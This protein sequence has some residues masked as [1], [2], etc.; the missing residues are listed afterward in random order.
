MK[1][2]YSDS[3]VIP[4][5]T[6]TSP[7][8]TYVF[9]KNQSNPVLSAESSDL[10]ES[11]IAVADVSQILVGECSGSSANIYGAISGSARPYE[12]VHDTKRT[13]F[14]KGAFPLDTFEVDAD[15]SG[16]FNV[17][18]GTL[19]LIDTNFQTPYLD[20]NDGFFVILNNGSFKRYSSLGDIDQYSTGEPILINHKF[21][22]VIRVVLNTIDNTARL[23][24]VVQKGKVV[25]TRCNNAEHDAS[26][27]VTSL[28]SDGFLNRISIPVMRMVVKK[29]TGTLC[30]LGTFLNP[31]YYDTYYGDQ[32]SGTAG[33]S[34]GINYDDFILTDGSNPFNANWYAGQYNITMGGFVTI[35][36]TLN[37]ST[38]LESGVRVCLSNG[39][40]CQSA[41][42]SPWT[43]NSE[44]VYVKPGFPFLV[45][46][47]GNLTVQGAYLNM[48]N[49]TV[50]VCKRGCDFDKIQDA[51][52]SIND[53]SASKKYVVLV[54][55][56]VYNENVVGKDYVA[57]KGV[58]VREQAVINGSSGVLYTFPDKEGG[59]QNIKLQGRPT[60]SGMILVNVSSGSSHEIL[61]CFLD[62]K[63]D[64]DG[65]TG[66]LIN[67][68]GGELLLVDSEL[69][70]NFSG[71]STGSNWHNIL[72]INSDSIFQAIGNEA[73]FYVNDID[74]YVAVLNSP[75]TSQE[76]TY[77]E[78]NNIRLYLTNP[79]YS[80]YCSFYYAH[81]S[82][83]DKFILANQL[84]LKGAGS[85]TAFGFYMDTATNN[86]AIHSNANRMIIE[87]FANNYA[88][89]V[90]S[91]DTWYS[92][93]DAIDASDGI[94]PATAGNLFY[95][96]SLQ[97]GN[98]SVSNSLYVANKIGIGT[99]TPNAALQVIGNGNFSGTVYAQNFSSNSP[100]RLQTGGVTRIF[101]NST[102]GY[103]G[104]GTEHP[105]ETLHVEGDAF[106]PGTIY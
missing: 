98:F 46:I 9:Y 51:I 63:S 56:G 52:D 29:N 31:I 57:I 78:A 65:V 14:Y 93:S 66:N 97:K 104:I 13:N 60:S 12:F 45:N 102:T 106:I 22:V 100:L 92:N 67:Q 72:S 91:G 88:A 8:M 80:G 38:L 83:T 73:E 69:E 64:T 18:T 40:N 21:S 10:E 43:N 74:D 70:Y 3:V 19:R 89:F 28:S 44:Q 6:N 103:V 32:V 42:D 86:G 16:Y 50:T 101:V 77:I 90:A 39:T 79:S 11:G 7:R 36:N 87:S 34:P 26:K 71:S 84:Y 2:Y 30:N 49:Q 94:S 99:T 41:S 5:G 20:I 35:N 68:K 59:L 62:L 105:S 53:A 54:Y 33:S 61:N 37:A 15:S 75:S 27:Q 4:C 96:S 55:P 82:S 48:F 47:S 81:G 58:S 24:A 23:M 17:S 76:R 1:D 95:T 85:G 25:Y